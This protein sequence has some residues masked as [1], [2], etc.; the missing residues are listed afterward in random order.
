[1]ATGASFTGEVIVAY[2]L[3]SVPFVCFGTTGFGS[4]TDSRAATGNESV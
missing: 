2:E 4:K 1:M 3:R